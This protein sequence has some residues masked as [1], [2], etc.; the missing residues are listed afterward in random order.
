[1][2]GSSGSQGIFFALFKCD[3]SKIKIKELDELNYQESW[4]RIL[5]Y[6][7]LPNVLS[8]VDL[9]VCNSL[10]SFGATY[11]CVFTDILH[12]A[13]MKEMEKLFEAD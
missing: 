13:M 5:L 4:I 3:H 12:L 2:P 9:D 8:Q 10:G 7:Q 11:E 6:H 1:M